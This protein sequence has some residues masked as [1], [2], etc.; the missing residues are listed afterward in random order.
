MNIQDK[1]HKHGDRSLNLLYTLTSYPPAIG[2]AQFLQHQTAKILSPAHEIQVVAFWD[3]NRSDWLL[4]TT[5]AVSNE[6]HDYVYDEIPVNRIGFDWLTKFKM[7]L[8]LPWY[9]LSMGIVVPAMASLLEAYLEPFYNQVDLVHNVRIGREPLSIASLTLA[10][11]HQIPFVLTPVHHPRWDGWRYRIYNQLYRDADVVL[12]L[13]NA[14]KDILMSLG[15]AEARI[16]VIGMGPILSRESS[17]DRFRR[18]RQIEGPIVLFIG[19]HYRYKGYVELLDSTELVWDKVPNAQFVFIGPPVGNSSSVF[20]KYSDPRIHFLGKTDLQEKTDALDACTLLCVPS[21]QESFGGVY[22]EAWSFGKPVIGCRIPAVSEVIDDGVNGILV[23][24]EP[25]EIARN[26]I[27]LLQNEGMRESM[28][29][30]GKTKA[31]TKYSWGEIAS[32]TEH[33]Y[34]F[35]LRNRMS[36]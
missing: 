6:A 18:K 7:G 28:G 10:H 20:S 24:Q 1:D 9:Y 8:L 25:S 21:T 13:T 17:T 32:R 26:I 15:V 30:E 14:E 27:M 3:S 2:G 29:A 12:A 19:Q 31:E 22:T 33:A 36:N 23:D 11:K 4:G 34:E 16:H 35:A 5:I